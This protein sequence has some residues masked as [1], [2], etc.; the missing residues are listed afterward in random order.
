MQA[1]ARRAVAPVLG[2][3]AREEARV[4]LRRV[5]LVYR[6]LRRAD[7]LYES[8]DEFEDFGVLPFGQKLGE[9]GAIEL[10]EVR[11]RDKL[12]YRRRA[13]TSRLPSTGMQTQT[14][15]R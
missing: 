10:S 4:E 14:R 15:Q 2:E 1:A 11:E 12:R 13:R 7:R 3:Q 9:F 6:D 5:A 8:P